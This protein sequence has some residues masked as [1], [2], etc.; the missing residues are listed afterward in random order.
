MYA[1]VNG[2]V[3]RAVAVDAPVGRPEG[4]CAF[5]FALPLQPSDLTEAGLTVT[6]HLVGQ[7]A[8]LARYDWARAGADAAEAGLARLEAR[9]ARMEE[10]QQAAM[11]RLAEATERRLALQQERIDAFIEAAATLLLDRLAG[12]DDTVGDRRAELH[13]LIATLAQQP[14]APAA[15][16]PRWYEVGPHAPQFG[17]GWHQP[18]DPEEGSFRWMSA[19]GV[20]VNP[21]PERAV[22]AVLVVIPH[23]Y[24]VPEPALDAQ[25]AGGAAGA[26]VAGRA[27]AMSNGHGFTL[28][29]LP[30][31]PA[32]AGPL[33]FETLR[34]TSRSSGCPAREGVSADPRVLSV[35]VSRV[36]F[37]YAE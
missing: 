7:E 3:A 15:T 33:R 16:P 36:V 26:G 20:L 30:D 37:L 6:L 32:E 14:A 8:P 23:L 1:R 25:F 12:P 19:S 13:G 34:L 11:A 29:I 4:G 5:R 24:R 35:A 9:L 21:A 27:S 2:A 28:R 22:T 31:Q 18:E 10:A 17:S